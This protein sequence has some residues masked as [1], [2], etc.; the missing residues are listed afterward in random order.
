MTLETLL[1]FKLPDEWE[2]MTDEEWTKLLSPYFQ[3]TRPTKE[4][5]KNVSLAKNKSFGS[6]QQ[7]KMLVAQI[8]ALA[9]QAEEMKKLK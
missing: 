8:Q 1:G 2:K 6:G 9:K 3:V 5:V 7:A 4:M